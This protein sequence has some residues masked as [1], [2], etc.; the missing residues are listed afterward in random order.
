MIKYLKVPN[1]PAP[2]IA[3]SHANQVVTSFALET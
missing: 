2:A 3:S 1:N